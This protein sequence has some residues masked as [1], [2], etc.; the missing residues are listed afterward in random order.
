LKADSLPADLPGKCHIS[1]TIYYK[2]KRACMNQQEKDK[3]L[4]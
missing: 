2:K 1:F 3:Q 4:C